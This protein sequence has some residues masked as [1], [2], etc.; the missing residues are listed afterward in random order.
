ME[1]QIP[2]NINDLAENFN[3][4]FDNSLCG[5]VISDPKGVISRA[6]QKMVMWTG[7]SSDDIKGKQFSDLL[8]I[9]GKIY[10]ETHLRPLLHMQGFFDEVV[11]ELST[12]YGQKFRV[13][14]N[15]FERRDENE[16]PCFIRYSI[17]KANDRLKYEQ[18]L[19]DAKKTAEKELIKQK[20]IVT[21]REQ[22]IAVLGHDLRNPLSAMSMAI[23]LLAENAS[24]E[25]SILLATLQRSSNRMI[26]LVKNIMDFAR[27]RLGETILLTRKDVALQ[28]VLE[29]VIS[30]I[31]LIYPK[32]QI[33][34]TF[35]I[36]ELVNCDADRIA[37]LLSNL[38]ANALT[39]GDHIFPVYINAFCSNRNLEIVVS[40]KGTPIPLELQEHL[41]NPFTRNSNQ[42]AQHGLGLGLYICSQIAKAHNGNLTFKSGSNETTFMFCMP[43]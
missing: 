17:V 25:N 27:T 38:M 36:S 43:C 32:R 29:Q 14:V 41:F 11:L 34:A 20:E 2:E 26:E 37:Q 16:Q 18:N 30:E 21:L 33:N 8:T 13:M 35:E 28:P 9:G 3:D 31:R 7:C 24:A 19:Q 42:P 22:L 4:F 12:T 40:N 39:H 23:E 1:S 6:N 10:Y 5:F 15:A